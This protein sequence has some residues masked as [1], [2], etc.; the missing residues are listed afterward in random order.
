MKSVE[1]LRNT[2]FTDFEIH[3]RTTLKKNPCKISV[4]FSNKYKKLCMNTKMI[5][6]FAHNHDIHQHKKWFI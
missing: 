4:D 1:Q 6:V 2:V 3:N 5:S